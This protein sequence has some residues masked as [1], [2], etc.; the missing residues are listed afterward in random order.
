MPRRTTPRS[1]NQPRPLQAAIL[2]PVLL[3]VFASAQTP[4]AAPP[5]PNQDQQDYCAYLTE[6]AQAQGDLLRTPAALAAFTQPD[7]GLPTQL[8]AGA[9]LSLSSVRKAGI[10]LDVA[11]KNC[12]L[13]K[14]TTSVQQSLQYAL[15]AIEKQAL[16]HRLELIDS[17]SRSLDDLIANTT[18][19]VDAQ[20][21]T[22]PMLLELQM[23][24]IKLEADHADTQS[25]I[26]ALYVPPLVPEPLRAQVADK[27]ANDLTN[28]Q[29]TAKLARQNNWDVALTVGV[30][31][32]V[33]PVASHPEPYG[34][35]TATYNFA[36]RAIDQH[37]DRSTEAYANWKKV[38]E[39]DA[40]RG[41]E[42]LRQQV[43]D[44]IAAQQTRL[45]ALQREAEQIAKN[46]QLVTV[47]NTSAAYDF[48]NQLTTTQIL[49]CIET[50]D[51]TFRLERLQKFLEQNY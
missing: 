30:H 50:G 27:Q 33:N 8:V 32:Q 44:N 35:V 46:L 29:A 14:A 45:D 43:V 47:P 17:A 2:A 18:K 3:S 24:K 10:T 39:T 38:Q 37:L 21:M 41:M 11:R 42:V 15:P 28:Q 49:L 19:M 20:N 7:T 26:A 12:S 25:K 5:N 13:Y 1:L 40:T 6:Q 51:S 36:S 9:T 16:T 31:Q 23:T 48:R 4:N 34:E 22:R